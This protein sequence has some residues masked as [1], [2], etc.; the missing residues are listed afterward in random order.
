MV[1]PHL[2]NLSSQLIFM[3]D[4]CK[5]PLLYS[6]CLEGCCINIQLHYKQ[7]TLSSHFHQFCMSCF[8]QW[9]PVCNISTVAQR[10]ICT[11][12]VGLY[13]IL[14]SVYRFPY[15]CTNSRN[16]LFC[17]FNTLPWRFCTLVHRPQSHPSPFLPQSLS[18]LVKRIKRV[19]DLATVLHY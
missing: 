10:F 5:A 8:W 7:L 17:C 1:S 13:C 2:F 9:L 19:R 14:D 18:L 16:S 3:G 12:S 4:Q 6:R 11:T 15:F